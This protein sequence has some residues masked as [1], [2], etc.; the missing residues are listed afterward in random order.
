MPFGREGSADHHHATDYKISAAQP[1]RN[2]ILRVYCIHLVIW[3]RQF[4]LSLMDSGAAPLRNEDG[5]ISCKEL[6]KYNSFILLLFFFFSSS[7]RSRYVWRGGKKGWVVRF[8]IG[9]LPPVASSSGDAKRGGAHWH[10][11]EDSTKDYVRDATRRRAAVA[12]GQ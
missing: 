11:N 2:R 5:I 9:V 12:D 10:A 7:G 3:A 4:W 8:R 6:N 1:C